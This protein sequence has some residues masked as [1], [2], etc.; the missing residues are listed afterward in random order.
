MRSFVY[1]IAT[2]PKHPAY[3]IVDIAQLDFENR[4]FR[5]YLRFIIFEGN[6]K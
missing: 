2:A 4:E 5:N 6:V 3:D 1:R